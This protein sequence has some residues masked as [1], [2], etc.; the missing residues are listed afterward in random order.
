MK[1]PFLFKFRTSILRDSESD[2]YSFDC[3]SQKNCSDNEM[4]L[5]RSKSS[6]AKTTV[7]TAPYYRPAYTNAA[8]KWVSSKQVRG[9]G[10]KRAGH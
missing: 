10:D 6:S 8:G 7:F 2:V 1:V 9:H 4:L 3:F 5:W